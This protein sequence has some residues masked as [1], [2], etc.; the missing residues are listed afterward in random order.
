MFYEGGKVMK[1]ILLV[2]LVVS[3]YALG[4]TKG[5]GPLD[6][7]ISDSLDFRDKDRRLASLQLLH[8]HIFFKRM[9]NNDHKERLCEVALKGMQ[10]EDF[11]IFNA[12]FRLLK[13][14]I[15]RDHILTQNIRDV[16]QIL[17]KCYI[18]DY[19]NFGILYRELLSASLKKTQ[20]YNQ[21]F[22]K[23]WLRNAKR[24]VQSSDENARKEALLILSFLLDQGMI[25]SSVQR[26]EIEDLKQTLIDDSVKLLSAQP[27]RSSVSP[28]RSSVKP[29]ATS[30]TSVLSHETVAG[31]QSP[32]DEGVVTFSAQSA[33]SSASPDR[34][35]NA[36][37]ALSHATVAEK[38]SPID[39]GVVLFSA[40]S[41]R[42]SASP[43][44]KNVQSTPHTSTP[45]MF[46]S[47]DELSPI[48]YA[49]SIDDKKGSPF[50]DNDDDE[51]EYEDVFFE[52]VVS[53]NDDDDLE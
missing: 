43:V 10:D 17:M 44:I 51:D 32:V 23:T 39:E 47:P 26:R 45:G 9:I 42:S 41:A 31:K 13:L 49:K 19:R 20:E 46:P 25:N 7:T 24:R 34:S 22:I 8:S 27:A 11:D 2:W 50:L 35:S 1:K 4:F 14:L 33:R 6:W 40:Q 3:S 48:P 38:Q 30:A 12:S 21:S 37:A 52:N 5:G 16:N 18:S 36:T 29:V 28:D 15:E 53:E